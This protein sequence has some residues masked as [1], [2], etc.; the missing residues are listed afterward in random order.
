MTLVTAGKYVTS[1]PPQIAQK[2]NQ[3]KTNKMTLN[4]N[5]AETL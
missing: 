1:I 3:K 4:Q 2:G 5:D